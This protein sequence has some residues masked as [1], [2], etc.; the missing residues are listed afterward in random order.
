M[1]LF[2]LWTATNWRSTWSRITCGKNSYRGG[3]TTEESDVQWLACML[4]LV[5]PDIFYVNVLV[6]Y[7][8]SLCDLF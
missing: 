1:L 8:G 2:C 4:Y 6:H 5:G 3:E 7:T